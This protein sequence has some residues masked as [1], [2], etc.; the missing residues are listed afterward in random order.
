VIL[1]Y[2]FHAWSELALFGYVK[3][4]ILYL[5]PDKSQLR[6]ALYALDNVVPIAFEALDQPAP[7]G[8]VR[9]IWHIRRQ[10]KIARLFARPSKQD[11]LWR[12]PPSF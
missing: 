7:D 11:K 8:P 6:Q 2:K 5:W 1:L 4:K 12:Q 9:G 3:N 10:F